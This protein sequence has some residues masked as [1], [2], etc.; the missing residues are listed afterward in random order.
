MISDAVMQSAAKEVGDI[1]M[2]ATCQEAMGIL[3]SVS[4][5]SL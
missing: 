2:Q 4:N 5:P 3:P 1:Y